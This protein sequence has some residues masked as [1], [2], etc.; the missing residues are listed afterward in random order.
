MITIKTSIRTVV[1]ASKLYRN[2]TFKIS[3]GR[4]V[5]THNGEDYALC[6]NCDLR[7]SKY[8]QVGTDEH[9]WFFEATTNHSDELVSTGKHGEVRLAILKETA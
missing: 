2:G 6:E 5:I 1:K 7:G 9:A 3:N 8:V 4:A